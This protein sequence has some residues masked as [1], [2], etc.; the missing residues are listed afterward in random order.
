MDAGTNDR[1]AT[2][3]TAWWYWRFIFPVEFAAGSRE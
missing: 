2:L 1:A 3:L